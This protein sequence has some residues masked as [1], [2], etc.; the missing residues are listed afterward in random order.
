MD[1]S[2]F[3]SWFYNMSNIKY[4]GFARETASLPTLGHFVDVSLQEH[5]K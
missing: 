1:E 4:F 5:L 2:P 3:K